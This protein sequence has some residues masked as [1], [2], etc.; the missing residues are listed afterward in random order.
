MKKT[1]IFLKE[2]LFILLCIV[3][4]SDSIFGQTN[5]LLKFKSKLKVSGEIDNNIGEDYKQ[6]I[7]DKALKLFTNTEASGLLPKNTYYKVTMNGGLRAYSVYQ[8]ENRFIGNVTGSLSKLL[9][10]N[11]LL[12]IN[13]TLFYDK[14]N[15][16]S[17]NNN[18]Y[19]GEGFISIP[20]RIIFIGDI[21]LYYQNFDT[22][23]KYNKF[24]NFTES[25]YFISIGRKINSRTSF[26]VFTRLGKMDYERNAF[27][28]KSENN[29]YYKDEFQCDRSSDIG[30]NLQY[31]R[32]FLIQ[33]ILL[34][35]N[36]ISN[37]YGFSFIEKRLSVIFGRKIFRNY[38]MKLYFDLESKRYKDPSEIFII[39]DLNEDKEQDNRS[40]VELSRNINE[41]IDFEVRFEW[42]RN[43]SRFRNLYYSK[44]LFSTGFSY[45]F[46]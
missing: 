2:F 15:D 31:F 42:C 41:N 30:I 17:R 7:S 9:I 43:E 10:G 33:A 5:P 37:S 26:S 46:Y 11:I 13:G 32:K 4:F 22:N 25:R 24:F 38:M 39:V 36:N 34:H 21:D 6:S 19:L 27:E 1:T 18:S 40:I 16:N 45:K 12:G 23:Y 14:Y 28:K 44:Y 35:R 20:K 3:Y 8:R 29:F